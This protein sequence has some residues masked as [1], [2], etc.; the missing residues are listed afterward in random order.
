MQ[1]GYVY[2][3]RNTVIDSSALCQMLGFDSYLLIHATVS[4]CLDYPCQAVDHSATVINT[5]YC[6]SMS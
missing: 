1:R 4:H 2:F 6:L 3:V 5:C